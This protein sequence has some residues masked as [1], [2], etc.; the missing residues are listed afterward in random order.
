[1]KWKLDLSLKSATTI[2]PL[3]SGE[4]ETECCH[5]SSNVNMLVTKQVGSLEK[6][7]IIKYT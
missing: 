1:M 4:T 6:V 3:R 5:H 7:G 2:M